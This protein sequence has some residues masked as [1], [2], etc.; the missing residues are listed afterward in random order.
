MPTVEI[1]EKEEKV[2]EGIEDSALLERMFSVG[3]HY[4]YKK[5]RRHP[6]VSEYIFGL[7]NRVEIFDLTQTALLLEKAKD[8][9]R[10]LG[11]DKKVLL[12]VGTKYEAQEALRAGA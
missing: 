8:F 9:A 4:G 1:V 2:K 7:K 12:M 3:A 5:S 11:K 6:S 10:S